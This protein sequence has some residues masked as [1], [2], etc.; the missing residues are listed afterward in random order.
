LS[1]GGAATGNSK[2]SFQVPKKKEVDWLDAMRQLEKGERL[3]G[4]GKYVWSRE[5]DEDISEGVRVLRIKTYSRGERRHNF[6][7]WK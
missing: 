7:S 6:S 1:G 5:V 4:R 2:A 3:I